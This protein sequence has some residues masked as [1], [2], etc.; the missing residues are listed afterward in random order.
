MTNITSFNKSNG[1][2]EVLVTF[3]NNTDAVAKV[4][5]VQIT[6][7]DPLKDLNNQIKE[8]L[9]GLKSLYE[10]SDTLNTGPFDPEV[11]VPTKTKP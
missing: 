5:S 3:S 10:F 9:N 2:L 8:Y 1:V 7:S 6:S 11:S 4:F